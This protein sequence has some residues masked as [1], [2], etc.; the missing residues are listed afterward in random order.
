MASDAAAAAS[1]APQPIF[2]AV[3]ASTRPLY[4]LLRCV[5]FTTKIHVLVTEEGMRFSADL[6]RVMQGVASLDK[7]LFTSYTLNIPPQE[8]DDEEPPNYPSF[9]ITLPTLLETLQIFGAV[10]ASARAQKGEDTYRSNLRNYRPDAFSNQTLGIGGTCCLQIMEDGGPLSIIIEESGVKTV[11]NLTTYLPEIPEDIPFSR[12]DLAYKIIM[13]S[14]YLLDALAEIAPNGPGRLTITTSKNQPH[15]TFSGTGDFGTSTVDFAKGREL[16]E[17][18][19]VHE[20][21][22]QTYKFELI[23]AATEAMRI[24]TKTSF[25][26]DRQGVLSLQFMVSVEGA[27]V[28]FLDFRFVPFLTRDDGEEDDDDEADDDNE[29]GSLVSSAMV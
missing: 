28:S 19:T 4:Q 26:G 12:D 18:F 29:G 10:D 13:Q 20:R 1:A 17:V 8:M 2:R 15:L 27:G 9:Q 24:A 5:N 16:L 3:A 6:S 21:W 14:R 11:A 7:S 22:S 23:K 25:R